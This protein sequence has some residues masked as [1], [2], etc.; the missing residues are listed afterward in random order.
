[1]L[2]IEGMNNLIPQTQKIDRNTRP[3]GPVT[4]SKLLDTISVHNLSIPKA[5]KVIGISKQAAY[6]LIERYGIT[7][8]DIPGLCDHRFNA[9]DN[10]EITEWRLLRQLDQ[11]RLQKMQGRDIVVSAAICRDKIRLERGQSTEIIGYKMGDEERNQLKRIA[12]QI[13]HEAIAQAQSAIN[14]RAIEAEYE[15]VRPQDIVVEGDNTL[16]NQE[17]LKESE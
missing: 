3:D 4:L 1:M 6:Q 7:V 5:A 9:A 14:T 17:C 11:T 15:M 12:E 2:Y 16:H 10:Y 8:E 13:A